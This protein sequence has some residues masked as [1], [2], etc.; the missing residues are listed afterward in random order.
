MGH[1]DNSSETE[2]D[3][4]R[5]LTVGAYH[6]TPET[7][8]SGKPTTVPDAGIRARIESDVTDAEGNVTGYGSAYVDIYGDKIVCRNEGATI[9][10][11]N[12]KVA[13]KLAIAGE[14]V[15]DLL[16]S[17]LDST[18]LESYALAAEAGYSLNL[19]I[20]AS[21][22]VMTLSL[23]NKAGTVLSTKTVDFPIESIVVGAS[24]ANGEITLTLQNGNTTSFDVSDLV[25][26]LVN[27]SRTI[28]GI[29]LENDITAAQLLSALGVDTAVAKNSENLITS[30]GVYTAIEGVEGELKS[31]LPLTGGTLT[32]KLNLNDT[33]DE[34]ETTSV[35]N[36]SGN[37]IIE[38]GNSVVAKAPVKAPY[39]LY[40]T[41]NSYSNIDIERVFKPD[42]VVVAAYLSAASFKNVADYVSTSAT[43]DKAAIIDAIATCPTGGT[44]KL[45]PGEYVITG[46]LSDGTTTLGVEITRSLIIKGVSAPDVVIRQEGEIVDPAV[47][48]TVK[49]ENVTIEDITFRMQTDSS[50]SPIELI[51]INADNASLRRCIFESG[52]NTI[53]CVNDCI[54]FCF[55]E[56]VT[57][58]DSE[59]EYVIKGARIE[60]CRFDIPYSEINTTADYFH[61]I[62]IAG[63]IRL[64][65]RICGNYSS[66]NK[67]LIGCDLMDDQ[68]N[69]YSGNLVIFGNGLI[70]LGDVEGEGEGRSYGLLYS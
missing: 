61:D 54:Y 15:T 29:S 28:A 27:E 7:D 66:A 65:G 19:S 33:N 9:E 20:N 43:G 49:A 4:S 39:Y 38:S 5:K 2:S 3:G 64:G 26:G 41:R 70:K 31:Y 58:T 13:E 56:G 1:T 34:E 37:F 30:G 17:K 69:A 18:A 46:D 36:E 50:E 52:E 45:L 32:G 53:D 57:N 48:F 42:V 22:Y 51:E 59:G 16:N 35:Y 55:A 14:S 25:S 11:D 24:Y 6:D 63:N 12:I 68:Y 47:L 60:D 40:S 23:L 44:V 21:T 8:D 10:I 62:N 67:L